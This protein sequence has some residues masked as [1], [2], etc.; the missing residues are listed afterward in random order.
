MVAYHVMSFWLFGKVSYVD[1]YIFS[2][3]LVG[4]TARNSWNGLFPKKLPHNF[5]ESSPLHSSPFW[6][7]AIVSEWSLNSV[8]QIASAVGL[9]MNKRRTNSQSRFELRAKILS[10][11]LNIIRL[12]AKVHQ[13]VYKITNKNASIHT[14]QI[15][16]LAIGTIFHT[17]F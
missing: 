6:P 11:G 10:S 13:N 12:F 16:L 5:L 9:K 8:R 1:L 15:L 14:Y 3:L 2:F 7:Y 17:C 4:T